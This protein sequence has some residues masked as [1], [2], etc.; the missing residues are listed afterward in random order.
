MSRWKP[1][2][3]N[4]HGNRVGD[5]TVRA[6]SKAT[7]QDWES[8]YV[9]LTIYGFLLSDMPSANYVW[10][11][12]LKKQGFKRHLVDDGGKDIY[13]VADFCKDNPKGTYILCLK[14]HVVCVSDGCYFD[15]W[16][17]G[18]EVPIYYWEKT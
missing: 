3:P 2:N 16:D 7:G 15:S 17:S 8:T 13:T 10:G 4:P 1:F 6:I 14:G 5:C 9:A 18:Q 11:A 12:Y